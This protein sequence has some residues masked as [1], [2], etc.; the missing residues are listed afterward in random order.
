MEVKK[1]LERKKEKKERKKGEALGHFFLLLFERC[2]PTF[3]VRV[4][5]LYTLSHK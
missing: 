1:S 2:T 3:S 5:V 4:L